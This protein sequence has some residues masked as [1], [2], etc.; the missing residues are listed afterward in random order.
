MAQV[1]GEL[2]AAML[3]YRNID[4]DRN[5]KLVALKSTRQARQRSAFLDLS[6]IRN[7]NISG[8]GPV[9]KT[10]LVLFGIETAAGRG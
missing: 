9:R 7:A 4:S 3:S 6:L 5:Q 10:T 1:R 8:I 2:D